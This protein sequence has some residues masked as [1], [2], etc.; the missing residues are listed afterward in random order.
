MVHKIKYVAN[1]ME[2]FDYLKNAY[3]EFT[4]NYDL[5]FKGGE[6]LVEKG[7]DKNTIEIIL[8]ETWGEN[9]LIVR[10]KNLQNKI[11][12]T[13]VPYQTFYKILEVKDKRYLL[14]HRALQEQ[15]IQKSD[16]SHWFFDCN[17]G[18][19]SVCKS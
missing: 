5:K 18:I 16:Q 8:Q 11:I 2:E 4:E 19:K 13:I 3:K 1:S 17:N 12:T 15:I 10:D 14:G 7:S 6:L 9:K